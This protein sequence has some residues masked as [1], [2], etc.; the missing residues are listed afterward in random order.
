MQVLLER[1]GSDACRPDGLDPAFGFRDG[2]YYL[3]EE[4]AQAILDLR[5]QRLTALEQDKLLEEYQ[6]ILDEIADLQEILASEVR[7][8]QV[9]REELEAVRERRERLVAE[10]E[11]KKQQAELQSV[12][13]KLGGRFQPIAP[14]PAPGADEQAGRVTGGF[15]DRE[16]A[17]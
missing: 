13:E 10:A 17:L 1:A 14:I 9:I 6:S 7:L 5:L 15:D 3:S 16:P 8:M 12:L 4:Q 2:V 11:A